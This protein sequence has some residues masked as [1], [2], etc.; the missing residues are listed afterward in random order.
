[1]KKLFRK[2]LALVLA[3]CMLFSVTA[4]GASAAETD[5]QVTSLEDYLAT[6]EAPI[7]DGASA[8]LMETFARFLRWLSNFFINKFLLGIVAG[9]M[10]K[11]TDYIEL[12]EVNLEEAENFFKGSE[13]FVNPEDIAEDAVW[14]VGYASA[15][16]LPNDF[17]TEEY[18]YARGSYIPYWFTNEIYKDEDGNAEDL[19]VRTVAMNDGRGV[20]I[21]ASIDCVGI[22]NSDIRKIRAAISDAELEK[23]GIISFNVTATHTHTGIDTQGVWTAPISTL[24]NNLF[25]YTFRDLENYKNGVNEDLLNTIIERTALTV[26][27]ACESMVEG[28][29]TFARTNIAD[30]VRDRTP[31]YAFDSEMYRLVFHP[32]NKSE[33]PTLISTFGCH[34]ESASYDYLTTNNGL[35]IDTKVSGDFVYYMEKV[36]NAAGYNFI[37]IQGNVGTNTSSRG[38]TDDGLPGDAHYS[39]VRFGYE[40]GYIVL[41]MTMTEEERMLLNEETGDLLGIEEYA[42]KEDYPYYTVWYEDLATVEEEQVLPLLNIRHEQ[43]LIP[44]DNNVAKVLLKTGIASN[45]L[46]YDKQLLEYYALT[47]I[48]YMEIGDSVKVFLDPGELMSELL[49]D[50]TPLADFPYKALRDYYGEDLIVCDLMNDAAGY[51]EPDPYYTLVGVQYD[52]ESGTLESD[53]WCLLVSMGQKTAS[54]MI[55][56]FI[57]LVE[58][59]S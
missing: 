20:V 10:P 14:S 27:D 39:A 30:Y 45:A 35:N 11:A 21:F 52:A 51:I 6:S 56:E 59:V 41:S 16:I 53:T 50:S 22:S 46:V 57:D 1:M 8:E 7:D 33:K 12:S 55:G 34:P 17:G 32:Y 48:G 26:R 9:L 23:Y 25:R 18:K 58:S 37:Y 43:V 49:L 29:L 42:N 44:L 38:N 15:S 3:L 47:E 40:L 24:A 31:P 2:T 36:C 13:Y 54:T 4:V 5:L 28:E 19:K